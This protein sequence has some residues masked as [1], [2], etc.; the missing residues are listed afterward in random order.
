MSR[1]RSFANL[2][3]MF[4]FD[5]RLNRRLFSGDYHWL[6]DFH[7]HPKLI[8]AVHTFIPYGVLTSQNYNHLL[9]ELPFEEFKVQL[10]L[11][12]ADPCVCGKSACSGFCVVRLFEVLP[13]GYLTENELECKNIARLFRELAFESVS[14]EF[15][16]QPELFGFVSLCDASD[17]LEPSHSTFDQRLTYFEGRNQNDVFWLSNLLYIGRTYN[18]FKNQFLYIDKIFVDEKFDVSPPFSPYH[19]GFKRGLY[20]RRLLTGIGCQIPFLVYAPPHSGKTRWL[21]SHENDFVDTDHMYD[22]KV[23]HGK[24]VTNMSH[25]VKSAQTSVFLIPTRDEFFVRCGLRGLEADH[26]WY[27][28]ILENARLADFIIFSNSHLS[29]FSSAIYWFFKTEPYTDDL[30]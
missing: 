14:T 17:E 5:R 24:V 3:T 1:Y 28:T 26:V 30:R 20:Y 2:V 23:M 29:E 11:L 21:Q 27:D 25:L 10:A 18:G 13:L 12:T 19:K 22:W 8:A 15:I 7:D 6:A 4:T 16:A 9:S